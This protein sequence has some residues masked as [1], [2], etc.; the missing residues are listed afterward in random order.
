MDRLANPDRT[1][2][3][4]IIDELQ[5]T[6]FSGY[7]RLYEN[8]EKIRH[9]RNYVTAYGREDLYRIEDGL[10]ALSLD[11]QIRQDGTVNVRLLPNCFLLLFKVKGTN[12]ITDPS[13]NVVRVQ[14]GTAALFYSRDE[15]AVLTDFCRAGEDHGMVVLVVGLDV[16]E[17]LGIS[18]GADSFPDIL[19]QIIS[20][21][22]AQYSFYY[23]FSPHAMYAAP[24]WLR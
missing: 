23:G 6:G 21:D 11:L 4:H 20:E 1:S 14:P 9:R 2:A 7:E 5:N 18:V 8:Y 22:V 24:I 3:D 19:R 16:F 10:Y 12:R 17:N 13:G 15:D